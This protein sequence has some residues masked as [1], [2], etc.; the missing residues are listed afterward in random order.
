[1]CVC[2]CALTDNFYL[3][4]TRLKLNTYVTD[5]LQGYQLLFKYSLHQLPMIYI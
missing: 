4:N 5:D 2:M 1:M 3:I